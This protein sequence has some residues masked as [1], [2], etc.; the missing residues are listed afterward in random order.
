MSKFLLGIILMFLGIWIIFSKFVSDGWGWTWGAIIMIIG[1]AEVVRNFSLNRIFRLWIGTAIASIGA[2]VFFYYIY[3]VKLW[4]IFLIGIGVSFIFQGIVRR[5]GNEIA[6]GTIFLGFG[7]LF[8]I[9][10]L[11]GWWLMKFFWPAF[12]VIPGLGMSLQRV[13]EK[14]EFKSS[15]FYLVV[16]TL[17][18]YVIALGIE[19]PVIWGIALIV[20]GIY[21]ITRT[22]E[23]GGRKN[24]G[25]RTEK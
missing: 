22:K 8:V 1:I 17:F 15:V 19:Y 18:L 13:F 23:K 7:I 14:K 9:S 16:L 11:F 6:P 25:R 20:I 4:P 2:I 12:I 5:N 24:E 3:G 10:E 21:L